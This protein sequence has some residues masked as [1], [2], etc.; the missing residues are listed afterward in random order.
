[1]IL[2]NQ[3]LRLAKEVSVVAVEVEDG[4]ETVVEVTTGTV[5]EHITGTILTGEWV[6]DHSVTSLEPDT[7]LEGILTNRTYHL[8]GY[9]WTVEHTSVVGADTLVTNSD[10]ISSVSAGVGI[11]VDSHLTVEN[12]SEGVTSIINIELSVEGR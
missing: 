5:T 6:V 4:E 12:T 9:V 1:L 11:N 3:K 10:E 2:T 8:E 7:R